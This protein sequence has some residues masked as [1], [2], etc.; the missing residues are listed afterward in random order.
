MG[1]A[2]EWPSSPDGVCNIDS[3]SGGFGGPPQ[4]RSV[5]ET[6]P[7][8]AGSLGQAAYSPALE[9]AAPAAG[10][11]LMTEMPPVEHHSQSS[12]HDRVQIRLWSPRGLDD[13]GTG[14]P[15]EPG[16]ELDPQAGTLV[17]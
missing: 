17:Q 2:V 5:F 12:G 14:R 8:K 9:A 15:V 7:P 3:A 16:V 6:Q 13:R 1:A 11:C 4:E 10:Q